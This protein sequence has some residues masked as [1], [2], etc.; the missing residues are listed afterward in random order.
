MDSYEELAE[1]LQPLLSSPSPSGPSGDEENDKPANDKPANKKSSKDL[2]CGPDAE[3]IKKQQQELKPDPLQP[4]KANLTTSLRR[5][6]NLNT[7]RAQLSLSLYAEAADSLKYVLLVDG[8][9]VSAW[10][11]RAECFRRMDLLT[12]ADLHLVK[13]TDIDDIDKNAKAVKAMNDKDLIVQKAQKIMGDGDGG[14]PQSLVE[15]EV[16]SRRSAKELL[17]EAVVSYKQGNVIFRE[18]FFSTASAKYEKAAAC[19][20]AAEQVM[21]VQL[22]QSVNAIRVAAHLGVAAANLLRKRDVGKAEEH[23]TLALK[24]DR[25]NVTAMLRRSEARVEL[26]DYEG[27]LDDLEKCLK[28]VE[29]KKDVG[30]VRARRDIEGRI[31]KAEYT[32]KMFTGQCSWE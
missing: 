32:W 7:G 6:L 11:A 19:A 14:E 5:D 17:E 2:C 16:N 12:L 8:G 9:N 23:C 29:K 4:T 3:K 1:P 28:L 27:A 20:A 21:N 31:R 26:T 18:Q 25:N 30:A 10:V 22:P 24:A 15:V 13:A